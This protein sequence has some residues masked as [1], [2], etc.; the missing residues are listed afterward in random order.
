MTMNRNYF[1]SS[2]AVALTLGVT[3]N[4]NAQRL[5]TALA[6]NTSQ[7]ATSSDVSIGSREPWSCEVSNVSASLSNSCQVPVGKYL[8]LENVSAEVKKVPKSSLQ[9]CRITILGDNTPQ[10]VLNFPL[11][12]VKEQGATTSTTPTAAGTPE[13]TPIGTAYCAGSQLTALEFPSGTSITVSTESV[14]D[15]SNV[16]GDGSVDDMYW[17]RLTGYLVEMTTGTTSP[18][19]SGSEE[20]NPEAPTSG[21]LPST[22]GPSTVSGQQ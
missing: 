16:V 20:L 2:I 10:A 4:V 11:L 1:L 7:T 21:S 17:A 14:V 5:G 13:I 15:R 12:E 3:A 6:S 19:T 8:I 22:S 18:P 9:G